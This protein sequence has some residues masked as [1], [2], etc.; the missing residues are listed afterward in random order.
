[1]PKKKTHDATARFPMEYAPHYSDMVNTCR[2]QV[3]TAQQCSDYATQPVVQSSATAALASANKLDKTLDE[4]NNA[5][6]LVAS[7]ESQREQDAAQLRRDH[8]G[9]EAAVNIA[10]AGNAP[11][12]LAW[13][14]QVATRSSIAPTTDP[15][16]NVRL[17]VT[18]VSGDVVAKCKADP[19]AYSYLFQMG[20]DPANLA[21]WPPPAM[22][23]GATHTFTG[24]TVG[25]KVY[26]RIAV[27]R[28]GAGMSQW[29]SVAEILVR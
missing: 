27:A 4:L 3:S 24:L 22:E 21:A 13:G 6:A 17:A 5:R 26:V 18:S 12:V 9:F 29:S 16:A 11:A 14:A 1:M 23:S 8:D 28:R 2:K 25:Q 7:L 10:S 19:S 20:T 15:P